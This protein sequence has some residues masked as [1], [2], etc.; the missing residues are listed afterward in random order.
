MSLLNITEFLQYDQS[1]D[2][3]WIEI[4]NLMDSVSILTKALRTL[5]M[6]EPDCECME[7]NL[8]LPKEVLHTVWG[9]LK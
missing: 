4:R 9:D 2:F 8:C 1:R 7:C 5:E 6:D 3:T